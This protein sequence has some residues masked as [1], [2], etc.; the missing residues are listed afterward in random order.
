MLLIVT[1]AYQSGQPHTYCFQS[2]LAISVLGT[3]L[4]LGSEADFLC[5]QHGVPNKEI[6]SN[7]SVRCYCNTKCKKCVFTSACFTAFSLNRLLAIEIH[8]YFS[9]HVCIMCQSI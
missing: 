7:Q 6:K 4:S 1:K 3:P 9:S 5:N 2:I 8:L